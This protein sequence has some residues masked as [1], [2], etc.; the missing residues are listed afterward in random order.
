MLLDKEFF[1][2]EYDKKMDELE[3]LNID[4]SG[5]NDLLAAAD[6]N[7]CRIN[8]EVAQINS[9]INILS[10]EATAGKAAKAD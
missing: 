10:Q 4:I 6:I 2:K 8:V 1:Q 3:K 7:K 9:Y 5:L